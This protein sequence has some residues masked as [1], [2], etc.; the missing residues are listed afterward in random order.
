MLE[1][2]SNRDEV[3]QVVNDLQG[4]KALGPDGVT[5]TFFQK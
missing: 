4:D 2:K 5:M 3:L 1:R